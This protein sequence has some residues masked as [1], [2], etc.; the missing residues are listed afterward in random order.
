MMKSVPGGNSEK[1]NTYT[2][3][4]QHIQ[5]VLALA[6]ASISI[7]SGLITFYWFAT[8]KRSFRHQYVLAKRPLGFEDSVR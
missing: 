2:L 5:Q 3:Q 1:S 6:S 4:E 8:M 7:L